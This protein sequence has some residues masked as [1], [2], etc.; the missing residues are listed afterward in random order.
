[1][2]GLTRK[3]GGV[4]EYE[5]SVVYR[6]DAALPSYLVVYKLNSPVSQ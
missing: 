6:P 1:M 2:R 4:L 5:T 3:D